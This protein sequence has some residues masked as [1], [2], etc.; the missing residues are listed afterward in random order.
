LA[1][2][3]VISIFSMRQEKP[4]GERYTV[5]WCKK[6]FESALDKVYQNDDRLLIF[7]LDEIFKGHVRWVT[8]TVSEIKTN[9]QITCIENGLTAIDELRE[10]YEQGHLQ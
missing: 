2:E 9:E 7:K 4:A 5:E 6:R 3:K 8:N 10:S 1:E